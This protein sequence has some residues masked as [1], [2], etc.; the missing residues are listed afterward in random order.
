MSKKKADTIDVLGESHLPDDLFTDTLGDNYGLDGFPDME[1][2]LGVLEGFFED[3][4]SQV[5][6]DA[7][8]AADPDDDEFSS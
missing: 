3:D 7:V 8:V 1:Y 4:T 2:G 6:G 5:G